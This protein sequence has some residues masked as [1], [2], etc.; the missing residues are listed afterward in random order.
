M[1]HSSVSRPLEQS[2]AADPSET[3]AVGWRDADQ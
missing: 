3:L 1:A 2:A